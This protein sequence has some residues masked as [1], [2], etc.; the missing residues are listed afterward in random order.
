[1]VRDNCLLLG[2]RIMAKGRVKFGLALI[3][4]GF[5][6]DISKFAGIEWDYLHA[7][8]DT[9]KEQ[10][11]LAVKQHN[12]TNDHHPETWG[13]IDEMPP[14]A[15]AEMVCDWL[16]RSQERGT[17]VRDWIKNEGIERFKIDVNGEQYKLIQEYLSILLQDSFVR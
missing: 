8:N 12:H 16:A 7:G 11:M 6:H 4:R 17:N 10:M 3:Q 2:E 9:P 5:C 14:L 13:G 1:M 15:V